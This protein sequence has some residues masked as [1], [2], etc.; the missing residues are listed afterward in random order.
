[1]LWLQSMEGI[2]AGQPPT[3]TST[4]DIKPDSG[5]AEPQ[6]RSGCERD[7]KFFNV[8]LRGAVIDFSLCVWKTV[9]G[10]REGG[11]RLRSGSSPPP[12]L[13]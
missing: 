2:T 11:R 4:G 7:D 6:R 1:M 5:S 8:T 9:A 13:C 10:R 12:S 3:Y